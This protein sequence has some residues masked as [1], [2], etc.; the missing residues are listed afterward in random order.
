MNMLFFAPCC[1]RLGAL[2]DGSADDWLEHLDTDF[3]VA[4]IDIG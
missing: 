4:M 3:F 2:K 1:P